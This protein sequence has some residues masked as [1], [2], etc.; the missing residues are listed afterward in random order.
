VS[1]VALLDVPRAGSLTAKLT[2]FTHAS[3]A[4]ADGL[5]KDF[6]A[7]AILTSTLFVN[8]NDTYNA[9]ISAGTDRFLCLGIEALNVKISTKFPQLAVLLHNV[10]S[11]EYSIDETK[12]LYLRLDQML[13]QAEGKLRKEASVRKAEGSAAHIAKEKGVIEL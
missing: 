5:K 9:L 10:G 8:D 11:R 4:D 1:N 7:L 2:N 3:F 12:K 13:R 6:R